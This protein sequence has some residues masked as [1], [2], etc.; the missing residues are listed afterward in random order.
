MPMPFCERPRNHVVGLKETKRWGRV[1][2]SCIFGRSSNYVVLVEL[3]SNAKG[4]PSAVA[5]FTATAAFGCDGADVLSCALPSSDPS[6]LTSDGG[7]SGRAG[8]TSSSP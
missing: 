7:C 1:G 6:G 4:D 2:V 8:S 5:S 3:T